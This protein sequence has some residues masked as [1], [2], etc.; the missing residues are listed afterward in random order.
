M[1]SLSLVLLIVISAIAFRGACAICYYANTSEGVL[2]LPMWA[3]T[4]QAKRYVGLYMYAAIP[5]ACLNGFLLYGFIGLLIAGVGTWLVMLI[6]NVTL[7][8]NPGNQLIFFGTINMIW[9]LI[10]VFSH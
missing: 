4:P 7:R 9:T 3:T 2:L 8:F 6:A 1:V 10:N 5:I